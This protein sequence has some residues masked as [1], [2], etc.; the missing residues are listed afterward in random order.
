MEDGKIEKPDYVPSA[1]QHNDLKVKVRFH[2]SGVLDTCRSL[3]PHQF[4]EVVIIDDI[5]KDLD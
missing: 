5:K 4:F 3:P 2:N 1:Y